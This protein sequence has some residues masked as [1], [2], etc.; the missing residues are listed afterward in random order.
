MGCATLGIS[1]HTSTSGLDLPMKVL[2][3]F[4]CQVPVCAI[5]FDCLEEL[6]KDGVNGK[7]FH[8]GNELAN[9][10]YDLLVGY[11]S[12]DTTMN[13]LETYR[14]NI[15]GMTRWKENWDECARHLIVGDW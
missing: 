6:V 5:G 8:D 2:D 3:M 7:I 11:P 14:Q 10:L 13:K 1:L 15:D 9:Q 12:N 4:G